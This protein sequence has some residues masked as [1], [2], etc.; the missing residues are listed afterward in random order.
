MG[1]SH[2][3]DND[4]LRGVQITDL[5][6]QVTFVT[7]YPRRYRGRATHFHVA[8]YKDD[9]LATELKTNQF[10]FDESIT[11]AVYAS[12]SSYDKSDKTREITNYKDNIFRDVYDG[13][14][15]KI[16]GDP[17]SG[18]VKTIVLGI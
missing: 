8:I 4:F 1:L 10:A 9:S 14:L 16:S 2:Q 6:G 18:Y 3:T 13:Q 17:G 15:L 7:I 5:N 11:N 12:G